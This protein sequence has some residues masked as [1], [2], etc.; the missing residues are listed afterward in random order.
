[1]KN[2]V[3]KSQ[4]SA[5]WISLQTSITSI[6]SFSQ[7]YVL[8]KYLTPLEYGVIG[9]VT[10]IISIVLIIENFGIGSAI[11]QKKD[12]NTT[13]LS[14]LYWITVLFGFI[15]FVTLYV[16]AEIIGAFY[17]NSEIST[18]IK[19]LSY[20]FL[21]LSF[22]SQFSILLNKYIDFK[23][24]SIINI[25]SSFSHFLSSVIL[26][27][28]GYGIW[29]LVYSLI[30]KSIVQSVL[31]IIVGYNNK[32]LPRFEFSWKA[33]SKLVNFGFYHFLGRLVGKIHSRGDQLIIGKVL[34]ASALGIYNIS[35]QIVAQPMEK[36]TSMF[37]KIAFPVY[38][39][40]QDNSSK[41]NKVF[42]RIISMQMF[43]L[44]PILL[45]IAVISNNFVPIFLGEKWM[46]SIIIIKII[47]VYILFKSIIWASKVVVLSKGFA[48]KNFIWQ[49]LIALIILP[50]IYFSSKFNSLYIVSI[51][52]ALCFF[53]FTFLYYYFYLS[54]IISIPFLDYLHSV[55]YPIS[56]SLLMFFFTSLVDFINLSNSFSLILKIILGFSIYLILSYFFLSKLLN[57]VLLL[58]LPK[59]NYLNLF[60]K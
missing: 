36:I 4:T 45:G 44:S 14:T 16:N 53:I 35:F 54:K 10:S 22:G 7:I 46:E 20:N 24:L 34:G 41:L 12:I 59:L 29:S 25:I 55:Y 11:I 17:L 43:L 52:L 13:Q 1:M 28:N 26:L 50:V 56:I 33:I 21:I 30:L 19:I 60:K 47:S 2:I 6:L 48:N 51:S 23:K 57:E 42:L 8:T 38:S 37:Q 18:I 31:L 5:R 32:W 27:L 39:E 49:C 40:I 58:I 9:I 15:L 3:Q